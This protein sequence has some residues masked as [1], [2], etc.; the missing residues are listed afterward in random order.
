MDGGSPT[1]FTANSRA[2]CQ[3][4]RYVSN[5]TVQIIL[6]SKYY[7]LSLLFYRKPLKLKCDNF[8][9]VCEHFYPIV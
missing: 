9:D 4:C 3:P 1:K 8:L 2:N 6:Y 7:E 5:Y